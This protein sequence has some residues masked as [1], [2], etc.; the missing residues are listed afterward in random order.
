MNEDNI[1]EFNPIPI[2]QSLIKRNEE[3]RNKIIE[4]LNQLK[5]LKD[6]S[7]KQFQIG[8]DIE[9]KIEFNNMINEKIRIFKDKNL[10]KYYQIFFD[11]I[12]QELLNNNTF[13]KKDLKFFY[14]CFIRMI[15]SKIN[16][17]I[18]NRKLK[19]KLILSLFKNKNKKNK[20]IKI[21]KNIYK[22]QSI[23]FI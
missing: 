2:N 6:L 18:I 19:L 5:S 1:M 20:I 16:L 14:Q 7:V 21:L 11:K 9:N 8:K 23:L 4:L 12:K 15:F 17:K 13:F 10:H 3:N 22:K